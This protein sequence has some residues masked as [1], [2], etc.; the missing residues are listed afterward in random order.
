MNPADF[1]EISVTGGKTS[2]FDRSK[3][4]VVGEIEAIALGG[5]FLAR[6]KDL[7]DFVVVSM[8]TGT[9]FVHVNGDDFEHIGG[10]GVG[11]GTFL[12]LSRE[13]FGLK[14]VDEIRALYEKG[15]REK[16]D[17]S[18]EE[19]VG[20]GIGIVSGDV[21][22]S[23]LGKLARDVDFSKEDLA[24]GVVNLVGQTI[25]TASCFAAKS[26]NAKALV[27]TGKLARIKA[28]VDVIKRTAKVY[29]IEVILPK[30]ASYV[31]AVGAG[32]GN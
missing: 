29:G 11:G 5:K 17:L 7:K 13:F 19:V 27:L 10:T 8:G 4:K 30:D 26:V 16:V 24:A 1:D 15:S 12:A 28:I 25:A 20:Q 18:V 9:C 31:A 21:T 23:N 22:A 3:F 32:I 6:E 2:N 14:D